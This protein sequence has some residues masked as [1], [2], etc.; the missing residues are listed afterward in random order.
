MTQGVLSPLSQ[1]L[2]DTGYKDET[3]VL[4]ITSFFTSLPVKGVLSLHLVSNEWHFK[5]NCKL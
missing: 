5:I 2:S 4:L 1:S 3:R